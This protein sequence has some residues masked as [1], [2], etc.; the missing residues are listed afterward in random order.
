MAGD[1]LRRAAPS[2]Q[3]VS[4]R[5]TDNSEPALVE[6][7]EDRAIQAVMTRDGVPRH[8]IAA[9]CADPPEVPTDSSV[10]LSVAPSVAICYNRPASAT[11]RPS[12][13]PSTGLSTAE[14]ATT[15]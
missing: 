2:Q 8:D 3:A 14:A 11:G 12:L 6:M 10:S 1:I 7:V 15:M 9:L 5:W 13:A 4:K